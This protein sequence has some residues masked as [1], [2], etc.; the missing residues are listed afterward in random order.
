[1]TDNHCFHSLAPFADIHPAAGQTP[2]HNC[3]VGYQNRGER[4]IPM[5]LE[6][7]H[8][9]TSAYSLPKNGKKSAASF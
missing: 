1:L 2:F 7:T 8:F 9:L 4:S 3:F 5:P 6:F